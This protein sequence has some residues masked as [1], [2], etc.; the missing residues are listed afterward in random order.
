[1]L[2][3]RLGPLHVTLLGV[4]SGVFLASESH[5]QPAPPIQREISS[6]T[7]AA[8]PPAAATTATAATASA[9]ATT[10]TAATAPASATTATA[11][12]ASAAA[13]GLTAPSLR[14]ELPPLCDG[15][16]CLSP[17]RR[18]LAIGAALVPGLVLHGAGS[19]IAERPRATKRLMAVQAVGIGMLVAGG[20]PILATY[21][22]P[23]VTFP[24]VPIAVT[25]FG[26]FAGSWLADIWSAAGADARA[27]L[28]RAERPWSFDAGGAWVHDPY[29]GH[30]GFVE[31]G[32]GMWWSR[33]EVAPRARLELD[34][35]S[36]EGGVDARWRFLGAPANGVLLER[37]HRLELRL[38]AFGRR[39]GNDDIGEL[40][41]E[42]AFG[43]R[44]DLSALDGALAGL[45]FEG[46][47]GLGL[48]ETRYPTAVWDV[49]AMLLV[50]NAIGVYLGRGAGELTFSYDQRR[51]QLVGGLFAGRAAGFLGHIGAELEL[52]VGRGLALRLGAELGAV[53]LTTVGLRYGGAP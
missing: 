30:R 15:A 5:G 40:W 33:L 6:S 8:T 48:D 20:A 37:G 45:F 32:G 50:R 46:E 41:Q 27:G 9:A 35:S 1:M 38:G 22:S 11:A 16:P 10:A 28:P 21:G 53:F 18:A 24:G 44:S 4:L 7:A 26:L 17:Q 42:A 49:G 51:D 12:T 19:W 23:Q 29:H 13:T 36:I 3:R 25:G 52:R 2:S 31:L 39:D 43:G 34:A 14:G 47:V